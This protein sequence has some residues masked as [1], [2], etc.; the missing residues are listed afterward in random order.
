MAA[1]KGASRRLPLLPPL[2][3]LV[4]L[5]GVLSALPLMAKGLTSPE[6]MLSRA[7]PGDA[8][9]TATGSMDQVPS[10]TFRKPG[11]RNLKCTCVPHKY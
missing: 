5:R 3:L 7:V 6:D 10:Y 4:L 2:P 1:S 9:V 11:W 8:A